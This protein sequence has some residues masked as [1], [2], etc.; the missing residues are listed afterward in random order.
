MYYVYVIRNL[1]SFSIYYGYTDDLKR[2]LS[3]HNSDGSTFTSNKG[4]WELIYYES[5]KSKK[6]A[7]TREK[8]L[9]HHGS[10][11]GHLKKRILNSLD[12]V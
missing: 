8:M 11:F 3:E 12:E 4:K 1:K 2:R 10:S 7:Q 6:D 9:K 5:Y